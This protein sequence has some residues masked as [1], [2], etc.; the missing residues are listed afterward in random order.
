M[1]FKSLFV[2]LLVTASAVSSFADTCFQLSKDGTSWGRSV[3]TI[4]LD[5]KSPTTITLN[6]SNGIRPV[7]VATFKLDLIARVRC[8]D[9]NQDIFAIANPSNSVLNKLSIKFDGQ[10]DIN[11]GKESGTVSVGDNVFFYRSTN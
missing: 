7:Q 5:N 1:N 2:F 4:C 10:R 3:E 9:C 11:T 6:T 8:I